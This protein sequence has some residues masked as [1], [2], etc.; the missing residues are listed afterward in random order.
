MFSKGLVPTAR[1]RSSIP[2]SRSRRRIQSGRTLVQP[3][4]SKRASIRHRIEA[5][6]LACK[7]ISIPRQRR[8]LLLR[9]SW[10]RA[11]RRA[12]R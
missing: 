6:L 12:Q 9:R 11:R 10:E 7:P 8:H 1:M 4:R 3:C 5:L 2:P